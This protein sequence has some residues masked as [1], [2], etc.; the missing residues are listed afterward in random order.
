[1]EEIVHAADFTSF[2]DIATKLTRVTNSHAW[3][4]ASVPWQFLNRVLTF[5]VSKANRLIYNTSV[6]WDALS[7]G[8]GVKSSDYEV[9]VLNNV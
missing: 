4:T 2:L 6:M 8:E 9:S 3:T 5:C 7:L 1:M